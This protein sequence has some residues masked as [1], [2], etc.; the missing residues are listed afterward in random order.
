MGKNW[1][2]M[3]SAVGLLSLP[4]LYAWEIGGTPGAVPSESQVAFPY[5]QDQEW[6]TEESYLFLKPYAENMD[7]GNK[8]IFTAV[9]DFHPSRKIKVKKPEFEWSSGIRLAFGKY[10]PHHDL[11]DIGFTTTYYYSDTKDKVHANVASGTGFSQSFQSLFIRPT[12]GG[13]FHWKLNY[14]TFDMSIGRLFEMTSRT[15]FHPYFGL[16][17][18]AQYQHARSKAELIVD[19]SSSTTLTVIKVRSKIDNDFWG[20]GPRV[21]SAFTYCFSSHFSLLA[22]FSAALLVGAQKLKENMLSFQTGSSTNAK[23]QNKLR[24]KDSIEVIRS[25]VEASLGLGW[26]RWL[27]N[28]AVRVAPSL[29]LEGSLWFAMNQLYNFY[30]ALQDQQSIVRRRH[31]NLGLM[32]VSFNLQVDF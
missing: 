28:G 30:N 4:S 19:Q 29:N 21:G 9:D 15:V 14:W 27:N 17:G 10:L 2:C 23:V 12:D 16:R 31:G 7:Y 24:S 8:N 26:E 32:G 20:L 6:F 13:T 25:N 11:W 1:A 5:S 22:N 18:S 3:L